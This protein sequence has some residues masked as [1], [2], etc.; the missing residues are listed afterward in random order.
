M[1]AVLDVSFAPLDALIF[2]TPRPFRLGGYASTYSLPLPSTV[3]GLLRTLFMEEGLEHLAKGERLPWSIKGPFPAKFRLHRDTQVMPY[4]PRPLDVLSPENGE[5]PMV[6]KPSRFH[7]V[8]TKVKTEPIELAALPPRFKGDKLE[9]PKEG[10]LSLEGLNA[11]LLNG[12]VSKDWLKYNSWLFRKAL[13]PG[14]HLGTKKT[15]EPGHFYRAEMLEA[16]DAMNGDSLTRSGFLVK[17]TGEEDVV[18]QIRECLNKISTGRLGGESRQVVI[19]LIRQGQEAEERRKKLSKAI[20]ENGKFKVYLATPTLFGKDG[21]ACWFP[22]G[23]EPRNR[24][25]EGRLCEE[26]PLTILSG[27]AMGRPIPLSGW[28]YER[29]SVKELRMAIPAGSVYYFSFVGPLDEKQV[30][31]RIVETLENGNLGI[32]ASLGFGTCFVGVW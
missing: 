28:D 4:F 20:A 15:V 11:Y 19:R 10:L 2:R 12:S 3:A 31:E 17:V 7:K 13:R 27:V 16:V 18:D 32:Q 8:R 25:L 5:Q 21:E 24:R 23:F 29:G 14:V 9:A 6:V 22:Q 30:L 26:G 1:T